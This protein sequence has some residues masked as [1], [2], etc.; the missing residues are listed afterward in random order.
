MGL[1]R[2]C[3]IVYMGVTVTERIF[4]SGNMV[5]TPGYPTIL[6]DN[7][8]HNVFYYTWFVYVEDDIQFC[9]GECKECKNRHPQHK[10]K[11]NMLIFS[12]DDTLS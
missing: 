9:G 11:N 4:S 1:V 3:D 12:W 7:V 8:K 6:S 2:D 10:I 5:L